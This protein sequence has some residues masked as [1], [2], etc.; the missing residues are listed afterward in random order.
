LGLS[1]QQDSIQKTLPSTKISVD[2][3]A[4]PILQR[5]KA[6]GSQ[7]VANA[8]SNAQAAKTQ[9]FIDSGMA[10]L[11]SQLG[12]DTTTVEAARNNPFGV[13]Q[14]I[15]QQGQER[16]RGIDESLNQQN[17]FYSG[18]RAKALADLAQ[19][20]A[21]AETNAGQDLR[22]ILGQADQGVLDAQSAASAR[23]ADALAQAESQ[24]AQADM[25]QAWMEA[26][27]GGGEQA[28]PSPQSYDFGPDVPAGT[29]PDPY[30][31]IVNFDYNSVIGAD[32]FLQAVAAG[33]DPETA[34]MLYG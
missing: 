34:A 3:N 25:Q 17:L 11:A 29:V 30:V 2:Y 15:Q 27:A 9:A 18:A 5:I 21:E 7:D 4:D 33:M 32:P 31:P 10:D 19:S 6:L 13:H 14:K 24:Q 23:E 8:R 12:A 16:G 22:S 28:A 20:Q 1:R 26:L